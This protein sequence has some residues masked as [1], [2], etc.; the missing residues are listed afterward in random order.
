MRTPTV[1]WAPSVRPPTGREIFAPATRVRA[2]TVRRQILREIFAP[3]THVRTR[4]WTASVRHPTGREI[5]APATRV[6][7]PT[8]LWTASMWSTEPSGQGL[9]WRIQIGYRRSRFAV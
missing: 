4:V 5:F 9:H 7:T 8:V 1:L 3:A 6:R 2:P